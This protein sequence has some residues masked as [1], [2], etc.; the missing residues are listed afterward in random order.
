MEDTIAIKI[1]AD[2]AFGLFEIQYKKSS[3]WSKYCQNGVNIIQSI[4][5]SS[6]YVFVTFLSQNVAVNSHVTVTGYS[7]TD[8]SVLNYR[9]WWRLQKHFR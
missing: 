3:N 8:F 7:Q 9:Q 2:H 5:Q 1:Q 6:F 4:N